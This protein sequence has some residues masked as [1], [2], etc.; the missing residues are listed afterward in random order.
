MGK[1][2]RLFL[3]TLGMLAGFSGAAMGFAWLQAN[4]VGPL[5]FEIQSTGLGRYLLDDRQPA[6]PGVDLELRPSLEAA[7]RLAD[8][9]DSR[10]ATS[11]VEAAFRRPALVAMDQERRGQLLILL[12][13][14]RPLS[15]R[16]TSGAVAWPAGQEQFAAA[17]PAAVTDTGP[18]T[19]LHPPAQ[20]LPGGGE[21]VIIDTPGPGTQPGGGDNVPLP[22]GLA[23][24]AGSGA[25][26]LAARR[27]RPAK[28][29]E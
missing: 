16:G 14:V 29:M 13:P 8:D 1:H 21:Q 11:F 25:L 9:Q 4:V 3:L 12:P 19:R 24:L 2:L 18:R 22:G 20:L 7:A 10:R 5:A 6:G 27:R 28:A 17:A 23:L 26:V 15:D